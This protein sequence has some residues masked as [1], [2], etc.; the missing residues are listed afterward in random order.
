M[1]RAAIALADEGGIEALSM[2]KLAQELGV[3]AMSLYNHVANKDEILAA[4]STSSS[5]E[6][7]LPPP[8]DDWKA[9]SA[10]MAISTHDIVRAAPVGEQPGHAPSQA[11]ARRGCSWMDAVL[12]TLREAGFSADLTH[13]AFHALDSHILGFTLWQVQLPARATE[14]LVGMAEKFLREMPADEYPY[15]VEHVRAAPRPT[16]RTAR[17]VR[18]RARPDPGQPRAAPRRG[19]TGLAGFLCQRVV[20]RLVQRHRASL[21]P[22]LGE[23]FLAERG[24]RS[25]TC[26]SGSGQPTS[27]G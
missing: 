4:S 14:E 24:R 6:I 26:R 15:L 18:V 7:E 22:G 11:A 16:S 1:L 21:R 23:R 13:H 19:L 2:R 9:G 8:E 25:A 17:A 10:S 5:S 27:Y 3:E 20:E 12:R